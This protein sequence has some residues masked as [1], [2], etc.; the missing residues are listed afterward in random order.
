MNVYDYSLKVANAYFAEGNHPMSAAWNKLDVKSREAHLNG[1]VRQ[2][3]AELGVDI[4]EIEANVREVPPRYDYAAFERALFNA[5]N[6]GAVADGDM[7]G[8]KWL[9]VSAEK[10][11]VARSKEEMRW[12]PIKFVPV[13]EC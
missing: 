12:L 6:G 5:L 7:A 11:D 13:I 1:A 4:R 9:G 10:P 2:L 3:N 8:P